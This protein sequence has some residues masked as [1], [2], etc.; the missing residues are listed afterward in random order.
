MYVCVYVDK[1]LHVYMSKHMCMYFFFY[2][3]TLVMCFVKKNISFILHVLEL[4]FTS[5]LVV[6][7]YTFLLFLVVED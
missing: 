1:T 5:L 2:K 3:N 7:I 6:G 4:S